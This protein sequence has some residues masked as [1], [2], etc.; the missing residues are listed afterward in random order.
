[1]RTAW[2][3]VGVL[4]IRSRSLIDVWRAGGEDEPPI[5]VGGSGPKGGGKGG[6]TEIERGEEGIEY[7]SDEARPLPTDAVRR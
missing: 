1:M 4:R 5:G 3:C 7:N 6:A 2:D